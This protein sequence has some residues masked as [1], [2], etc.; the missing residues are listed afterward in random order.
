MLSRSD[1]ASAFAD[2]ILAPHRDDMVP[3]PAHRDADGVH[4]D[5][6][7]AATVA[8]ELSDHSQPLPDEVGV[9]MRLPASATYAHVARLL[10][11]MRDDE[12]LGVH[13]YDQAIR[14]LQSLSPEDFR[15]YYHVVDEAVDAVTTTLPVWPGNEEPTPAA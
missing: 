9:A 12:T 8:Y 6:L 10:W 15:R 3:V 4:V 11:C 7:P 1:L 13:S 2:W 14:T 5:A